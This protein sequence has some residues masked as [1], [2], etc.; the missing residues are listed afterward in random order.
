MPEILML[1]QMRLLQSSNYR[2]LVQKRSC[3]VIAAIYKQLYDAV[4]DPTN[5]YQNPAVLMPRKPE[6]VLELMSPL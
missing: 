3:E 5:M 6:Q 1:P 2:K 4:H